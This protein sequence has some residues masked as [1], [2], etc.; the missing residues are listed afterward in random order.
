[1]GLFDHAAGGGAWWYRYPSAALP[2]DGALGDVGPRIERLFHGCG[3][4][5]VSLTTNVDLCFRS[6]CWREV[7]MLTII[8][9]S[10]AFSIGGAFM[11]VSDGFTKFWPSVMIAACFVVGAGFLAR[12][13]NRGGLSTTFVIGLGIEAVLSVGIGLALLGERLTAAQLAG[14][15]IILVGLVTLKQG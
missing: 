10:L 3:K 5:H 8:I 4:C 13:V 11:G 1:M 2:V 12:A 15:A 6:A 14:I 7:H 9:G